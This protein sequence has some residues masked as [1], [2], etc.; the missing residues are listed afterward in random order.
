[1]D[2]MAGA[3]DTCTV[4]EAIVETLTTF[5]VEHIFGL[6]GV[7]NLPAYDALR[8]EQR[9]RLI[10]PRNESAA[11]F[12]AQGYARTTWKPGVN[13]LA[14]GPGVTNAL[15]GVAEAYVN[16]TPMV[17]L[18]GGVKRAS[19][20]KG[21][22]HD[23]D[24]MSLIRPITKWSARADR[25]EEVQ[26]LLRRAFAE[27]SSSR[28]RPTFLEVPLD[29]QTANVKF[30]TP[31][32]GPWHKPPEPKT[33]EVVEIAETLSKARNPVIVA[34]G[35]V[36][37]SR[38][39]KEL[40]RLSNEWSIPVATTITAKEA[41]SDA[42]PLALGLLND[43]VARVVIPEADVVL[44]VGCRF[45]ERS[46]SA[47]T[48]RIRGRLI[49]VD[50]DP[51]EIGRNYPVSRGIVSDAKQ[52]L[53]ALLEKE[54]GQRAEEEIRLQQIERLKRER[55][56]KY[57]EKL[58][59]D[60]EPLKPQRVM[61]EL[62]ELLPAGAMVVCDSGN[63]AWWPMMF[64]ES[65]PGR[66]FLFPSGN[67]SM[68]FALP[69]AL[70]ARCATGKVICITGDGGFMMQLAELATA[71]QEG[72]NISIVL[73]NDGGY[74]AIRHYQRF[75]YQE[76]YVGVDLKNP[77]FARLAEAFGLEGISIHRCME[78]YPSIKHA[79]NSEK[80]TVLDIHVDPREVALP[81]WIVKSFSEGKK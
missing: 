47:W 52:F 40:Q 76:R 23:L 32:F 10:T 5:N 24:H 48:L 54:P 51:Q 41:I 72:L 1:M 29:L 27:A 74:G 75:N 78:L 39:S 4:S 42:S 8:D 77:D 61:L 68:G 63:N 20:G 35:G 80:T 3:G 66:R 15:T 25:A 9:I 79:L 18:A 13:L 53:T 16:S 17:I 34:G 57:D 26:P 73:L 30:T 21:A 65:E 71:F 43:D 28:M 55:M 11:S 31:A 12:M 19:V 64:L 67:V 2:L 7:H 6:P 44:A 50:I 14:P 58:H 49:H 46:T 81:D 62:N 38:A 45:A 37:C 22:I 59:S 36:L 60:A 56:A 69:A 33:S 70:G